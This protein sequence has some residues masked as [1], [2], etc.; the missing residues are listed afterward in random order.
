MTLMIFCTAALSLFSDSASYIILLFSEW[1][2][3]GKFSK[4]DQT[5]KITNDLKS[6]QSL[7]H[8]QV[9]KKGIKITAK[10][11]IWEVERVADTEIL[12]NQ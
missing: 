8:L 2:I 4:E 6:A 1:R 7:K 3:L 12:A 9:S 5:E 11:N 10:Q